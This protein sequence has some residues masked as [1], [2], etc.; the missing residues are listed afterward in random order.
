MKKQQYLERLTNKTNVQKAMILLNKHL[1][2]Y[3]KI[4]RKSLTNEYN[5]YNFW[6]KEL[7]TINEQEFNYI[8]N[9]LNFC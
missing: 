9:K 4:G 2:K 8:K 3:S 5:V 1:I 6:L 7:V